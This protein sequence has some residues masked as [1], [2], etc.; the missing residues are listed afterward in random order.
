MPAESGYPW[1][2][3]SG[4]NLF[5]T[6]WPLPEVCRPGGLASLKAGRGFQP[7]PAPLLRLVTKPAI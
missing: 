4:T 6:D 1:N 7:R 2:L 5:R 3:D